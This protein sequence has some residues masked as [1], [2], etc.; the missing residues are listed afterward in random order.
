[1]SLRWR[2]LLV[3][4]LMIVLTVSLSF[5]VG[6]YAT[7]RQF[8]DF[9]SELGRHEAESL[10]MHLSRAYTEVVGWQTID[11]ALEQA[12]YFYGAPETDHREN[13][14]SESNE[15]ES[16][17]FHVD[18]IRVIILD[19]AGRIV[20]DNFSELETGQ[21]AP[22]LSG[23][24]TRIV[25]LRTSQTVGYAYVD[26]HQ[27]FLEIESLGFLRELLLRSAIS[28]L[29]IITIALLLANL[30]SKYI[31]APV[32]ALTRAAQAIV[33][34]DDATM[35]PVASAD[36]LGQMSIAFNQM[37][38][39]LQRQRDMR[40]QLISDVSHELN[41]PLTI[42]QLEAKGLL[43]NLQTPTEAAQNITQEVAIL[44]NLV[45]DLNWLAETDTGE[46][47][48]QVEACEMSKLLTS[49]VARWQNQAQARQISLT[50]ESRPFL[51]ILK[52]DPG[53]IR[54]ALGNI[55]YNALQHSEDG[56]VIIAATVEDGN[57]VQISVQDNGEGIAAE[58]LLH[59]FDRFYR[60]DQSRSRGT[61]LGLN[62]ARSIIEAHNGSIVIYSKG[63]GQGTRVRFRLPLSADLKPEKNSP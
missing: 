49:E 40:R 56:K 46:L 4:L 53:R 29:L 36:E 38:S 51:P 58:D 33:Q 50:L 8:D 54:Q 14:E 20:R 62:I 32:I 31:I 44:R 37:T 26:V 9:V 5:A 21:T 45:S 16:A 11:T 48:L 7:Q 39:A 28:G 23:K 60:T 34:L 18:R 13:A 10:A 30:F 47:Q 3:L 2:T 42:V 25:D 63:I 24:R 35:L 19:V 52:L 57:F 12:G 6:Y 22:D 17:L 59:V 55:I 41:T 15:E 27:D 61:G 1:M 43:D